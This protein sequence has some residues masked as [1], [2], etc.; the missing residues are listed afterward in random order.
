MAEDSRPVTWAPQWYW[1]LIAAALLLVHHALLITFGSDPVRNLSAI[2]GGAIGGLIGGGLGALAGLL[3]AQVKAA[4][5]KRELVVG[6]LTIIGFVCGQ[7]F[8]GGILTGISS[9]FPQTIPAF[10]VYGALFGS[11]AG[12]LPM[13]IHKKRRENFGNLSFWLCVG[14]GALGGLILALPASIV[15]T[16]VGY[17]RQQAS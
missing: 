12:L 4:V 10:L 8:E 2:V 16:L 5:G 17:T 1:T 3:F 15:F 7:V 9:V 6:G 14:V 13:L 11:F